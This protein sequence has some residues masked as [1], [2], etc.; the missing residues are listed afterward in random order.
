M[1][2]HL[3]D[4]SAESA[5]IRVIRSADLAVDPDKPSWPGIVVDIAWVPRKVGVS[6]PRETLG[7]DHTTA[8]E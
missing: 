3:A 6:H 5:A 2:R 8:H 1:A 4:R 7:H